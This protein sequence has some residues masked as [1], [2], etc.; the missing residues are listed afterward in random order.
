M[1][2]DSMQLRREHFHQLAR[3][4]RSTHDDKGNPIAVKACASCQD[5]RCPASRP[6]G[7][8]ERHWTQGELWQL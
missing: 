7:C 5:A 8:K 3:E 1:D 4:W 2:G 6:K